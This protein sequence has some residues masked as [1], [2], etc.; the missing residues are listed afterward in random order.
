MSD[1]GN[2]LYPPIVDS[3]MPAFIRTN[4]DG[5]R[6]YFSISSYNSLSE[7]NMQAVQV[8]INHQKTN[9]T[10]L[11]NKDYPSGIKLSTMYID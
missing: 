9:V 3:W 7:I 8:S 10:A 4:A 5:C 11:K 1:I 6:V 2:N